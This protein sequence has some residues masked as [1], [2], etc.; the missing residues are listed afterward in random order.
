MGSRYPG[1][2][3][4]PICSS[5]TDILDDDSTDDSRCV[6]ILLSHHC[7]HIIHCV[8]GGTENHRCHVER[9]APSVFDLFK[10]VSV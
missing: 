1:R 2:V 10:I 9:R 6:S 8:R 3:E 4:C 7:N 5:L